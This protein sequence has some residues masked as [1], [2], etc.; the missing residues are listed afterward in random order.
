DQI[1]FLAFSGHK[2]YAPFGA[3][4]LI[5][6]AGL[7]SRGW[8]EYSGGGTVKLVTRERVQWKNP[9]QK[10]EAGSPNIMGVIALAEAVK[11][12]QELGLDRIAAA[13]EKLFRYTYRKLKEIKGIHLYQNL[14]RQQPVA[15]I[16]FNIRGLDHGTTAHILS[17]RAGIA[18][19]NGCFCAQPYMQKLLGISQR[20]INIRLYKPDLP[21]PGMVRI[22]FGMYNQKYE[23][24]K[25]IDNIKYITNNL[26]HFRDKYGDFAV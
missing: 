10:E 5:T 14:Y 22:S 16:P 2:M 24:D 8:P 3:G 9:P 18:V 26:E 25:L 21:H 11:K 15:I 1:D 7:L 13:E 12:L 4:V 23:V 6:P 20:E 17:C 19:R